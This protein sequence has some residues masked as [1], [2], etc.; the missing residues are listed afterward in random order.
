MGAISKDGLEKK[1]RV[2][3]SKDEEE[4]EVVFELLRSADACRDVGLMSA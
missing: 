2:N 3:K 4:D 1:Q